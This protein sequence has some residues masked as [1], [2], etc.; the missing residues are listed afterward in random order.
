VQVRSSLHELEH[1]APL[2]LLRL[3]LKLVSLELLHRLRLLGLGVR[4]LDQLGSLLLDLLDMLHGS[5]IRRILGPLLLLG[6]IK[7]RAFLADLPSIPNLL[8]QFVQVD[9]LKSMFASENDLQEALELVHQDFLRHEGL[10]SRS[11]TT[12]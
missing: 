6:I 4:L 7:D 10:R 9:F 2:L 11:R 5:G 3:R 12:P 1:G 8:Q